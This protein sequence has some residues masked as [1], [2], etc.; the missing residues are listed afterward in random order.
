[1]ECGGWPPL[2]LVGPRSDLSQNSL[3]TWTWHTRPRTK[4]TTTAWRCA[5]LAVYLVADLSAEAGVSTASSRPET[6]PKLTLASK[7][8]GSLRWSAAIQKRN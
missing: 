7:P 3:L 5:T 4:N 6:F 8:T 2:L 1:M